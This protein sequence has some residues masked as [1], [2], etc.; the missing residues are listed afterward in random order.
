MGRYSWATRFAFHIRGLTLFLERDRLNG[1]VLIEQAQG[2]SAGVD[3]TRHVRA[4]E[5][6]ENTQCAGLYGFPA[7]LHARFRHHEVITKTRTITLPIYIL[8]GW[9]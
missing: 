1:C 5:G 2:A 8:M 4:V 9:R 3:D 7:L 6:P